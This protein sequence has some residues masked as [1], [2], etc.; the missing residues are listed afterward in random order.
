MSK[1]KV[2]YLGELRTTSFHIDSKSRIETDAPKDNNGLGRKFSPTDLVASSLGSCLLTI[3]G[4]VAKR[5]N[6]DLGNTY[7]NIEKYMSE[8]PRKISKINVD[9][10]FDKKIDAKKINLLIR[11]SKHCPVHNSLDKGI[12]INI[13]FN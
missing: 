10:F 2:D 12:D 13:N 1:I 8:K 5:H 9:I 7:A 6:V 11:A 4:I 3:M